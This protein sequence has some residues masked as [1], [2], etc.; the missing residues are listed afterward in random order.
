MTVPQIKGLVRK[1]QKYPCRSTL[2]GAHSLLSVVSHRCLLCVG[3]PRCCDTRRSSDHVSSTHPTAC[4]AQVTPVS[5]EEGGHIFGTG[6]QVLRREVFVLQGSQ[7]RV[8]GPVA[9][10]W[11]ARVLS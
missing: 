1:P 10:V 9:D 6:F 8:C 5:Q 4:C 7:E 11:P 2:G 3:T